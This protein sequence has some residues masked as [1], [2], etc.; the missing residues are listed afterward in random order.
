MLI[1]A[2]AKVEVMV[3]AALENFSA[4]ERSTLE[5]LLMRLRDSLSTEPQIAVSQPFAPELDEV[6]ANG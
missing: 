5:A 6:A 2:R 1:A 4:D 3:G